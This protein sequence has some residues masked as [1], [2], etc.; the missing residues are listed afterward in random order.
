MEEFR[1]DAFLQQVESKISKTFY[2]YQREV[3]EIKNQIDAANVPVWVGLGARPELIR[4][5]N[6]CQK[7]TNKSET[8]GKGKNTENKIQIRVRVVPDDALRLQDAS[9]AFSE[10]TGLK[11]VYNGESKSLNTVRMLNTLCVS[12]RLKFPDDVREAIKQ[13]QGCA[14]AICGEKLA[15]KFE[16]DH[17]EAF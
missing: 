15:L 14:C 3:K 8:T 11:L 12:R 16:V 10:V 5:L 17:I 6:V 2:S 1:L 7:R 9:V 4:F 13:K